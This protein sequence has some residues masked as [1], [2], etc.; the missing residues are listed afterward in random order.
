MKRT[1]RYR[2]LEVGIAFPLED[3][4]TVWMKAITAK[5]TLQHQF[6]SIFKPTSTQP[7]HKLLTESKK[8]PTTL[9]VDRD[10]YVQNENFIEMLN[11]TNIQN[12]E[13]M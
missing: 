12:F 6:Q 5:M 9:P 2:Q 8:I 1:I 7:K 4:M 10:S 13:V 11:V 3:Y